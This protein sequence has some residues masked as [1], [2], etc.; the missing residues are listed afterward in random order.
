[1]VAPWKS[2]LMARL[3]SSRIT[4]FWLSPLSSIL[5]AADLLILPPY[6]K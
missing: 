4:S 2:I 3:K 5:E 6:I 1:M